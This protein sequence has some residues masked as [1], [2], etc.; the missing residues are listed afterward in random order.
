M[1]NISRT[2]KKKL[3]ITDQISFLEKKLTSITDE[4]LNI[5]HNILFNGDLLGIKKRYK[6]LFFLW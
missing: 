2:P 4:A 1:E 6:K 5:E 3:I